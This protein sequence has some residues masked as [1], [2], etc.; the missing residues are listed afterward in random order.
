MDICQDDWNLLQESI[1]K[2]IKEKEIAQYIALEMLDET[3][4]SLQ[5]NNTRIHEI[6][7]KKQENNTGDIE[8][9][10]K[11]YINQSSH[12]ESTINIQASSKIVQIVINYLQN[13]KLDDIIIEN[14]QQLQN[15]QSFY[16]EQWKLFYD[17][18]YLYK[19]INNTNNI[20]Q[21]CDEDSDYIHDK[22]KMYFTKYSGAWQLQ[23]RWQNSKYINKT[24]IWEKIGN[25]LL[26]LTQDI[27]FCDIL[28]ILPN[29]Q[30]EQIEYNIKSNNILRIQNTYSILQNISINKNKHWYF[31]NPKEESPQQKYIVEPQI[32]YNIDSNIDEDDKQPMPIYIKEFLGDSTKVQSPYQNIRE[33]AIYILYTLCQ[34]RT[35]C[36][37][38][39]QI[40]IYHIIREFHKVVTSNIALYNKDS[41]IELDEFIEDKL[42]VRSNLFCI[43]IYIYS[44]YNTT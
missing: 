23:E 9:I 20:N 40:H 8:Y 4:A 10:Q 11:S 18:D 27:Y 30:K 21:L 32:Q 24:E 16:P 12:K 34:N 26:N 28:L 37:Y 29:T 2:G 19:K 15:N 44:K 35:M 7:Y 17:S 31:I 1:E 13:H 42:I 38:L 25:I 43:Y 22:K 14:C 6:Q 33:K 5:L 36:R 3:K 39:R 41:D